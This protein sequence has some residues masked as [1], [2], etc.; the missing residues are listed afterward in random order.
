MPLI[1]LTRS[2]D[3]AVAL[4]NAGKAYVCELSAEQ[5]REYRGTLTEPGRNSPFRERSPEENLAEF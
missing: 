3:Y 5:A 4:I 2:N 1:I